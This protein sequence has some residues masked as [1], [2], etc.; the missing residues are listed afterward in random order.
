LLTALVVGCGA[1]S[2]SPEAAGAGETDLVAALP[3]P[4]VLEGWTAAGEA[5]VYE[6]EDLFS[7][8]NGQAELYFVYGFEQAAV[9]SYEDGAGAT[10][11]L[12]LWRVAAPEDAYGLYTLQAAGSTTGVAAGVGN[13][14]LME[15][16]Q[17]LVFWQGRVYADLFVAPPQA[18]SESLLG[19]AEAASDRL[20]TGGAPPAVM[21]RLPAGGLVAGSE[22]FFHQEL[23]T[24]DRVWLGGE[25]VLGLGPETD[26]AVA[27]YEMQGGEAELLLV[28]YPRAD[29]AAV[30]LE[31]LNGAGL[32]GLVL[33]GVQGA[34][35]GS[36]WGEV[37]EAAAQELLDRALGGE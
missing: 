13:G 27:R 1:V 29:E 33:S 8:V 19:L 36:V 11:R 12:T 16:G 9:R 2:P 28:E 10:M 31:A 25:N 5:E 6:R 32:D 23:A 34:L 37:E 4:E 18:D 14:G 30:A 35:L 15:A 17:R 24:Q 7:L 20:P 22:V 3:G 26:G 21:G